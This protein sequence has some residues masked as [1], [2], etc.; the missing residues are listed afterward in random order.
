MTFFHFL[1]SWICLPIRL[2]DTQCPLNINLWFLR[3]TIIAQWSDTRQTLES[4]SRWLCLWSSEIPL[5]T[6]SLLPFMV[7][8]VSLWLERSKMKSH[9]LQNS[10]PTAGLLCLWRV[11]NSPGSC[12]EKG[13]WHVSKL[14]ADVRKTLRVILKSSMQLFTLWFINDTAVWITSA[15]GSFIY[16]YI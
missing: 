3:K 6:E 13:L 4:K 11:P 15:T 7:F 12:L 14:L 8:T 10:L 1:G 5:T 2:T 16:I 9:L